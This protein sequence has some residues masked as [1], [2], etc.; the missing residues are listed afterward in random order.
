MERL[1]AEEFAAADGTQDWR[2][3]GWQAQTVFR[4]G[5][6]ATGLR[7]VNAVG[8]LAER[9]DHHPDVKLTYPLVE[10]RLATHS[11]S[12][13]TD[14]D[15]ALAR[16]ISAAARELGVEADPGAAAEW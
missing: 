2:V 9:A 10:L 8:E 3:L 7:L 1:T 15:V 12:S 16:E 11:T 14:K 6:F 13:L 4:T 5:D